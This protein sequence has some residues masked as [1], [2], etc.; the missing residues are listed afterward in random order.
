MTKGEYNDEIEIEPG[1][2]ASY[3]LSPVK[4]ELMYFPV[5]Y[6]RNN[7]KNLTIKSSREKIAN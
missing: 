6:G 3:S 2:S 5:F 7:I 4:A 1:Y